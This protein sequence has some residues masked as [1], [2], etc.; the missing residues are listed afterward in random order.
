MDRTKKR[1]DIMDY[2]MLKIILNSMYGILAVPF[3]RYFNTNI[4]EA[5]VSCGRQTIKAS[6]KYVNVLLNKPNKAIVDILHNIN[7]APLR[8][9]TNE[10]DFVLYG[11]TDSLFIAI[12]KLFDYYLT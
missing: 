12:G 9:D 3:S 8:K 11:D 10:Q 7:S 1:L 5:I 4:A 6:E 2:R